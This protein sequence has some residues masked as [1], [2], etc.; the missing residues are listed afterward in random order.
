MHAMVAMHSGTQRR[1][2]PSFATHLAFI[3]FT[4]KVQA[5][6]NTQLSSQAS[7]P[8]PCSALALLLRYANTTAYAQARQQA[9][10]SHH[11]QRYQYRGAFG[12]LS[13]IQGADLKT[14]SGPEVHVHYA[15]V[16]AEDGGIEGGMA[17]LRN[18]AVIAAAAGNMAVVKYFCEIRGVPVNF[19]PADEVHEAF[20]TH[21]P[22]PLYVAILNGHEVLA[23]YLLSLPRTEESAPLHL[24]G[25]PG[26]KNSSP[27]LIVAAHKG[28][29]RVAEALVALGIDL[30]ARDARGQLAVCRAAFNCHVEMVNMLLEAHAKQGGAGGV[31]GLMECCC[32]TGGVA[33]TLLY[34]AINIRRDVI[35]DMRLAT[36]QGLVHKWGANVWAIKRVGGLE[37]LE[38]AKLLPTY[39]SGL[40]HRI[41]LRAAASTAAIYGNIAVVGYFC[42]ERGVPVNFVPPDE[43]PNDPHTKFITPLIMAVENGHENLALYLLSLPPGEDRRSLTQV[44]PGEL[45]YRC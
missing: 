37:G 14:G 43:I 23:L 29:V 34:D 12:H 41:L 44:R 27:L 18:G 30:L 15:T 20:G 19:V 2:S 9:R 36:V 3:S 25:R 42:E 8:C 40:D 16:K 11:E 38:E 1:S 24:N 35:P 13:K 4:H 32:A 39:L 33:N 45:N 17:L 26:C 28:L 22:T 31:K 6:A 7:S 10:P 5:I 21:V